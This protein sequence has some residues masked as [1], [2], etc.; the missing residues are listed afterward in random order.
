MD[1]E[2]AKKIAQWLWSKNR[3]REATPVSVEIGH[4]TY[5]AAQY[6][7]VQR[8]GTHHT[9][10]YLL[11]EMPPLHD[12]RRICYRTD[13]DSG[14]DWHLIAWFRQKADCTEWGE[15][16]PFGSHFLLAQWSPVENWAADQCQKRPY[17]RI[18]MSITEVGPTFSNVKQP[19]ENEK[20]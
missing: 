1:R 18:Q 9:R 4:R 16:S 2:A 14:Y 11:G 12:R 7:E 15:V 5:P 20:N 8:G 17:R 10:L 13:P 3:V 19:T 6:V